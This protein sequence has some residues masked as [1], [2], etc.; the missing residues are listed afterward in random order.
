MKH[1]SNFLSKMELQE[2]QS[3]N[4]TKN[5]L[6]CMLSPLGKLKLNLRITARILV[7]MLVAKPEVNSNK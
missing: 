6:T 3:H 7:S 4:P 2:K 1:F 5:P